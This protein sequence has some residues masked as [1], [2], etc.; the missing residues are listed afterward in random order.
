MG[1]AWKGLQNNLNKT[2]VPHYALNK[3][4]PA[5]SYFTSKQTAVKCMDI[6]QNV[7]TNKHIDLSNY[8]FIEPGAGAGGFF[9]LLPIENRI[10]IDIV[11]RRNDVIMADYLTW[12]PKNLSL[13]YC[14]IGNPPFGIRG[15]LA[16][17]FLNRSL[18]F[19]ELV[20]FILPMSFHSNGKGST[21]SRVKNGHL[22]HS[23]IL[24]SEKF[25]SPDNNKEIQINALFQIWK[26]GGGD[27]IFIN[28]DVS[29]YA[30][31]RTVN[32]DPNR[33]CGMTLINDYD[34][35][36]HS[37][38][39]GDGSDVKIVSSFDEV[40]YKAG[41]GIILKKEKQTILN[42][43]ESVN[44]KNYSSIATNSARHIRM[45]HIQKCL[46]D[47]GFGRKVSK[48]NTILKFT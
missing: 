16:L 30:D 42:L 48:Q 26:R 12:K 45:Y 11:N 24:E 40:K 21:M 8:T 3:S 29:E 18:L 46:Y 35:F 28:Y 43:L 14:T 22:I 7:C 38:F 34:F 37:S 20:A 4:L 44:W 32:S 2:D 47:L 36:I 25:F 10:G 33:Y 39:F 27:G 17:A 6:L 31:I 1:N 19:S 5:D 23:E 15:T 13:N 9:D 41:Y